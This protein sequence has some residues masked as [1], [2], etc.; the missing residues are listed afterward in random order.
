M[1]VSDRAAPAG[2]R[3][4][5]AQFA[6]FLVVGGISFSL[7]YGLF[8]ILYNV[9]GVYYILSSTIS[10]ATSV[11]LNYVL[12]R[13]YVFEIREDRSVAREFAFYAVLNVIAL[14]LNQVILYASVDYLSFSPP[15]GKII[16]TAVVLVY[17]FVSRKLL[18]ERP[19]STGRDAAQPPD[20]RRSENG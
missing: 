9:F 16:A 5:V 18:L 11:V 13:K 3:P 7:D 20:G 4:L 1:N 6:K 15:V 10:F 2:M 14:F 17:N 8:V 12:S 19:P